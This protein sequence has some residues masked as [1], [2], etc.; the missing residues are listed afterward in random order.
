MG[1]VLDPELLTAG[2]LAAKLHCSEATVWRAVRE[3]GLPAYRISKRC[4]R[5]DWTTV[6]QWLIRR[7]RLKRPDAQPQGA[8]ACAGS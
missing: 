1:K 5:F 7:R 4:V 8:D 6:S 2:E 3:E